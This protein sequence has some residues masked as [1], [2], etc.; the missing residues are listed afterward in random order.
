METT[1]SSAY[2]VVYGAIIQCVKSKVCSIICLYGPAH[3]VLYKNK[4]PSRVI[5]ENIIPQNVKFTQAQLKLIIIMRTGKLDLF[6]N[7]CQSI[8]VFYL[9][10]SSYHGKG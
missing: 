2:L 9:P 7:I 10:S 4:I 3:V 6:Y 1:I 5:V 8:N